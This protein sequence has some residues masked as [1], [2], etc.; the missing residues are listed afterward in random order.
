MKLPAYKKPGRVLVLWGV[1][2]VAFV[3]L[4]GVYDVV[5]ADYVVHLREN[6]YRTY[7]G[8]AVERLAEEDY[9]GALKQAEHAKELAPD[10]FEP[11]A[12][13]GSIHYRMK[14]WP[15]VIENMDQAI[16]NGDPSRGPRMD[17]LWS[18][19]ELERY[20]EAAVFGE[21]YIK[22]VEDNGPL[23]QFT[24]EAYLR[25]KHP[26]KAVPLL[27]QAMKQS[28]DNLRQLRRLYN[29][30]KAMGK[31]KEA[32]EVQAQI[33]ALYEAIDQLGNSV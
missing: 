12:F 20:E 29:A 17:I 4:L 8:F 14:R 10:S 6:D 23:L 30:Y 28:P 18:L 24:A 31:E 3:A 15:L 13:A 19:I 22:E 16:K 21:R 33:D 1:V 25:A 5:L 27:R 32:A 26:E 7:L 11:F 9:L 2:C